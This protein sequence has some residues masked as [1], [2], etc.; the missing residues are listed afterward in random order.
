MSSRG[1]FFFPALA[2]LVALATVTGGCGSRGDT[3]AE[4]RLG[5]G[6]APIGVNSFLWQASLE[7]LD[8][9]PLS[10]ADPF[11]GVIITDWFA[12][13]QAP[14]ERFKAQVY[15]LDTRLR[16]DAVKVEFFR[17]IRTDGQWADAPADPDTVSQLEN[18]ILRKARELKLATIGNS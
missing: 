14:S 2:V 12:D 17:Q 18:A 5:A 16:A 8:F 4:A 9:M 3:T 7:T 10:S 11:G 6:G 15:I 13:A 1:R